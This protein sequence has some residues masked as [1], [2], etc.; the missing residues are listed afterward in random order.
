VLTTYY[1]HFDIDTSIM[2][3]TNILYV[4][5]YR[6][7]GTGSTS[8][9]LVD[10]R[11]YSAGANLTNQTMFFDYAMPANYDLRI[12]IYYLNVPGALVAT[13]TAKACTYDQISAGTEYDAT[14]GPGASVLF[15]A[16]EAP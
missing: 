10:S 4:E 6:N 16:M 11:M 12:L 2:D 8:W 1:A 9:F 7:N 3:W 14:A 15:Q 13:V 5:L